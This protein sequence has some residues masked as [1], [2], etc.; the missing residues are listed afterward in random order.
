M[1]YRSFNYYGLLFIFSITPAVSNFGPQHPPTHGALRLI[2][3]PLHLFDSF[4]LMLL[5][6]SITIGS[7]VRRG[8]LNYLMLNGILSIRSMIGI[9]SSNSLFSISGRF[10]KVG[11]PP[12]F[13]VLGY[14]YYS[15]SYL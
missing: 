3:S 13:S 5:T 8:L 1:S 14:Q 11:Y 9:L 2:S 7:S 10:G 4:L 6:I 15:P 12:S